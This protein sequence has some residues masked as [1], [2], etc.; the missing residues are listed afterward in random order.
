MEEKVKYG[1]VE[2]DN[3]ECDDARAVK[4]VN[5]SMTPVEAHLYTLG[6]RPVL[7]AC[8]KV[9]P[10]GTAVFD[11][12]AH[13]SVSIFEL[14]VV[15]PLAVLNKELASKVA[16]RGRSYLFCCTDD[17]VSAMDVTKFEQHDDGDRVEKES[18]AMK[19]STTG[20]S[21]IPPYII[22]L[23]NQGQ[24]PLRVSFYRPDDA[25]CWLALATVTLA[26]G[27]DEDVDLRSYA[28]STTFKVVVWVENSGYLR[29]LEIATVEMCCGRSYVLKESRWAQAALEEDMEDEDDLGWTPAGG[30][31][32]LTFGEVLRLIVTGQPDTTDA[33][34][35]LLEQESERSERAADSFVQHQAARQGSED[36]DAEAELESGGQEE[37]REDDGGAQPGGTIPAAID[38]GGV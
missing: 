36:E 9:L 35:H 12:A 13:P 33:Q 25:L 7:A 18:D 3:D 4:V 30:V 31:A 8:A 22:R 21:S 29:N 14:M 1:I 34:G 27:F 10:S 23:Q 26:P 16:S 32:P 37:R 38:G 28:S 5:M 2:D 6:E 17:A 15:R 20:E 11:V 24:L 19:E